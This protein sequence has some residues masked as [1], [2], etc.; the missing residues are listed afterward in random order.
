MN[1]VAN[2]NNCNIAVNIWFRHDGK[3][4][5]EDCELPEEK[6]SLDHFHFPGMESLFNESDEEQREEEEE[7]ELQ[8]EVD[9]DFNFRNL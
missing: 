9:N 6:A 8:D 7:N 2:K 4:V 1:S 5:P 3:H